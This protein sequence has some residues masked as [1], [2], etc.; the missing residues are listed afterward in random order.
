MDAL[1]VLVAAAAG[2]AGGAA[3]G[4]LAD[5]IGLA[6]YGPGT[7]GHDPDDLALAPL[8]TP[9]TRPQQ[10]GLVVVGALAAA[11]L[12]A[13]LPR[14]EIVAVFVVLL[15]AYLTAM[16]VDLQYLRLPNTFTYPA[17]ALAVG[18]C[19]LLSARLDVTNIGIWV[20]GLFYPG[21]LL[22]LRVLYQLVRGREGM[23]LGDIKLAVSL[24]ATTGWLG[25]ALA[26]ADALELR[27][28]WLAA[29]AVVIYALLAGNFL[30]AVV[31]GAALRRVDREVPFGPAL[32]A[33]WLLVVLLADGIVG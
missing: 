25:A 21:V 8:D 10:V 30:G 2:A 31:G 6:R 24:G 13:Q 12:A 5:R 20:G 26:E 11:G 7:D 4:P 9:T 3:A 14:G 22:L 16:V 18:G 29:L 1:A 17:A 33:G 23:G 32:V 28:A 27:P 15:L 19:L